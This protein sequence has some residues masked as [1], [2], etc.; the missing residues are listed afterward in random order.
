MGV[1]PL[2]IDAERLNIVFIEPQQR[3]DK[4]ETL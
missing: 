1:S 3:S 4:L 2:V